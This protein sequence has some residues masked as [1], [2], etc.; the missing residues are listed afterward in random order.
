MT[1]YKTFISCNKFEGLP[2]ACLNGN[3]KEVKKIF[4]ENSDNLDINKKL[5]PY[6]IDTAF[7]SRVTCLDLTCRIDNDEITKLFL[8][9]KGISTETVLRYTD[10]NKFVKEFNKIGQ[11]LFRIKYIPKM[12]QEIP[13]LWEKKYYK[14]YPN[15][16]KK[17]ILYL[18]F[19]FTK[20]SKKIKMKSGKIIICSSGFVSL[21]VLMYELFP[22]FTFNHFPKFKKKII[23]KKRFY[24]F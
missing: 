2:K 15:Q 20:G 17:T 12:I 7:L 14:Y 8:C 6:D 24:F 16:F 3:V 10:D 23:K 18:L 1:Y 5:W 11:L 19:I 4:E 22:F 9:Y 21:D 13:L